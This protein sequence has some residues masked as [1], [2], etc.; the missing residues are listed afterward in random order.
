M[1]D[2]NVL[3]GLYCP[4]S[5]SEETNEIKDQIFCPV[6]FLFCPGGNPLHPDGFIV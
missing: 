5:L 1:C 2:I 3:N 6:T 4:P